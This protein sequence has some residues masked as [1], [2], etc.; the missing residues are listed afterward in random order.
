MKKEKG[1]ILNKK[2]HLVNLLF[3]LISLAGVA[4][5]FSSKNDLVQM[6]FGLVAFLALTLTSYLFIRKSYLSPLKELKKVIKITANKEKDEVQLL[7]ESHLSMQENIDAATDFVREIEKGNLEGAYTATE[8]DALGASLLSMREYLKEISAQEKERIWTSEGLAKFSEL[9][10]TN[11]ADINGLC[12][13]ILS[14]L[15]KYIKAN[16]GALFVVQEKDSSEEYMEMVACYAYDRKKYLEKKIH[17]GEGLAGQ[18]WIENDK[19]FLTD[20]PQDYVAINSG[21]GNAKPSC[22]LIVPLKVNEDFFGVLELA[23]FSV[24]PDYQVAFIEKLAENLASTIST[25]KVNERTRYLLEESQELTEQMRAQE[26]EMRQN[27]EELTAT[28]EELQRKEG[29][30]DR[31]LQAALKEIELG[32]I[33]QQMNEIALQINHSIDSTKRDLKFLSNVPPVQGLVRAIANDNFD[34]Q[35]NSSF[36]DWIERM[37]IIFRNF[38][39]NKELFQSI[40]FTNE[41]GSIIY[42]LSFSGD[43]LIKT[44]EGDLEKQEQGSFSYVSDLSKGE[45]YVGNIKSLPGNVLVMEFG[46]PVYNERGTVK[47]TLLV[48]LFAETI[49]EGINSKEDGLNKFSL[50]TSEGVC[51]FG[52]PSKAGG[53]GLERQVLLNP[54]QNFGLTIMH[55]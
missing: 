39:L 43:K 14:Q 2:H 34:S 20:I 38:M 25:V 45:V 37:D 13:N 40:T 47:G 53:E 1:I 54:K 18:A 23:S 42:Q 15:V 33:N 44:L 5:Y 52:N 9:L 10:R 55:Q 35:S 50:I 22:I 48:H 46:I 21:L 11:E 12:L 49:I 26:E 41:E 4:F 31:K 6:E 27:L 24:I 28:Q 30:L 32:R 8:N 36:N 16:Q 3:L 17:K 51:I 7:M 19:V 29:E